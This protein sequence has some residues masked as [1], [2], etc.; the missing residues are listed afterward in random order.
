MLQVPFCHAQEVAH[1]KRD[2]EVLRGDQEADTTEGMFRQSRERRP[3]R[4]LDLQQ[5]Q[6]RVGE[7]HPNSFYTSSLTL[8]SPKKYLC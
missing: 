2:R 7:E 6:L 1:N 8:P 3:H 5:I 4:L